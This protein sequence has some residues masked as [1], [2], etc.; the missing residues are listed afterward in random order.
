MNPKN[1]KEKLYVIGIDAGTSGAKAILMDEA[2]E[3]AALGYKGYR[4]YCE[5]NCV[6]QD[7]EDWWKACVAAVRQA[8]QGR[9]ISKVRAL[10]LSAQ[11][12]STV[13]LDAKGRPIRRAITWM[14]T[15][16][17]AEADFLESRLG[18]ER[19][20]RTCGWRAGPGFDAAKIRYMKNHAEYKEAR[21]YLS[22]I[23]YINMK[24]TGRAVIDPACAA[25]RQLYNIRLNTWDEAILG[26]VGTS[27]KELPEILE[28]GALV[29]RLNP[30]AAAELGLDAGLR[31]Y[32]GAHDQYCASIGCGAVNA[33]DM[34]VSTGTAWVL[35]GITESPIF[36]DTYI[37][38]CPH[39][40]GNSYGNMVSLA[41]AGASYQWIKD[42][43]FP[44]ED[45]S[46][47]DDKAFKETPRCRGLFF[48]PWLSG[49]SYPVWNTNARGG[50]IGMDFSTNPC[51][52]AL[53]VMESAAFS[54]KNALHDFAAWGF[55]ARS[56]KIMGGAAKSAVWLDIL[57]AL[58]DIPLYKMEISDTC[59]LG[60]AFI[61]A[62]G[63][64]WYGDYASIAGAA[65]KRG[66]IWKSKADR[67][68]YQEKYLRGNKVLS[69]LEK[70]FV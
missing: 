44:A 67:D 64:G 27:E 19:I 26:E 47:I 32:N 21:R 22:T 1:R 42:A 35:M 62:R 13:A 12:A 15:R 43:C 7:C 4:L 48:L 55:T 49:A 70:A 16:A 54:L 18:K 9:D 3:T 17:Q 36:S 56:I 52:M 33:G 53:A 6:E 38:A 29:G 25:I 34:L 39:P 2:G 37:S 68:W 46:S 58:I 59:A 45:F 51:C 30:E 63:E 66:K 41:G 69:Y 60:A 28:T 61:A 23:D 57:A 40:A 14:D 5:G 20:Y 31:V 8:V 11:G 50:F 65:L 24:L 10:S